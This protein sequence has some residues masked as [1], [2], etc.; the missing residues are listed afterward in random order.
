LGGLHTTLMWPEE[1]FIYRQE[2]QGPSQEFIWSQLFFIWHFTVCME[3][4]PGPE[5]KFPLGFVFPMT[6]SAFC[7]RVYD[8]LGVY[9]ETGFSLFRD[10]G[11]KIR[12]IALRTSP[13]YLTCSLCFKQC[14]RLIESSEYAQIRAHFCELSWNKIFEKLFWSCSWTNL[15]R[16]EKVS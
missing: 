14:W 11:R 7:T 13:Q 15:A 6:C 9:I 8:M 16:Q 2:V 1:D 4:R 5:W 12:C 3:K 10:R